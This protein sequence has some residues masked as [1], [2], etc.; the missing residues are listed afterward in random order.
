MYD[1]RGRLLV[2]SAENVAFASQNRAFDVKSHDLPDEEVLVADL[3]S[4]V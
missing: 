1:K 3:E 4:I 2:S